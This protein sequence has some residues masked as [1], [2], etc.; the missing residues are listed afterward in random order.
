VGVAVAPRDAGQKRDVVAVP[1]GVGVLGVRAGVASLLASAAL[2]GPAALV[3]SV[4]PAAP[5]AP[6]ARR[7]AGRSRDRQACR[8]A[9]PIPTS[10]SVITGE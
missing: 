6:V 10:M 3:A 4:A 7:S 2:V 1:A 9:P 8:T 5:A